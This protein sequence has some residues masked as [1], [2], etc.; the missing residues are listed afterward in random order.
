MLNC[1]DQF[2]ES[3]SIYYHNIYIFMMLFIL[4][5]LRLA[6]ILLLVSMSSSIVGGSVAGLRYRVVGVLQLI[7]S[8]MC[9]CLGFESFGAAVGILIVLRR[10]RCLCF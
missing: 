7:V 4:I 3:I 9:F 8:I 6:L 1:Q 2:Q 5:S 10:I